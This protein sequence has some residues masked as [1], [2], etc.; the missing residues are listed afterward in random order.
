MH[1]AI[2]A[3]AD[4]YQIEDGDAAAKLMGVNSLVIQELSS[5]KGYGNSLD[6]SLLTLSEGETSTS[7]QLCYARLCSAIA[8]IGQ[9]PSAAELPHID[10]SSLFELPWS[11]LLRLMAR[12]PE[13]THSAFKTLDPG[14]IVSYLFRMAEELTGCLGIADEDEAG[15]QC[16][17]AGSKYVARAVLYENARQ[18]LENGMRLLGTPPVGKLSI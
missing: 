15:G 17:A 18:I 11:D 3:N 1:E 8:S 14:T 13:A 2:V 10:Y 9:H 5:R 6:F 4:Q 12:Y 16:S 7:L